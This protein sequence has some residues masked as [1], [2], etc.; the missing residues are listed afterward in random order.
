MGLIIGLLVLGA[1]GKSM[2]GG[3]IQMPRP[4]FPRPGGGFGHNPHRQPPQMMAVHDVYVS[5]P[6][7][8]RQVLVRIEG[9][10]VEGAILPGHEVLVEGAERNGTVFFE[11]GVNLTLGGAG[12][13]APDFTPSVSTQTLNSVSL[14]I[15]RD[16]SSLYN[17]PV[18]VHVQVIQ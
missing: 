16:V 14:Q 18:Y 10:F 7:S 9:D 6:N 11:A 8:S 13:G 17:D 15:W 3:K 1:V 4:Q 5:D 2:V 12:A